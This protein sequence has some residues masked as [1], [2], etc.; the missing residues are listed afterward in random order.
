MLNRSL[1]NRIV[2]SCFH[3]QLIRPLYLYKSIDLRNSKWY[4]SDQKGLNGINNDKT[5]KKD[6]KEIGSSAANDS[7]KKEKADT[8]DGDQVAF[9]FNSPQEN[10]IGNEKDSYQTVSQT[11]PIVNIK[12]LPSEAESRRSNVSKWFSKK[13]D[14]FQATVF[15]ASR[16]LNDATGYSAIEQLKKAIDAEEH[17]VQKYRSQVIKC[18]SEYEGAVN[19]RA[20]SQAEINELLQ[21]KH[22]WTPSDLEQFTMLYRDNHANETAVE[23]T[24]DCLE[25]AE[26]A[27]ED[28]R[29]R[30]AKLIGARY[31]EEQVWSDKIRRASTWGT[32]GLMGFNVVLFLVVQLGLEPWKRKRLVG[33]FE[34]KVRNV[35]DTASRDQK[36]MVENLEQKIA[37]FID[38]NNT[39]SEKQHIEPEKSFTNIKDRLFS[40]DLY[41]LSQFRPIELLSLA[42]ISIGFGFVLGLITFYIGS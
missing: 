22:Q 30:A 15:T 42:G 10:N 7:L 2:F 4:S 23:S 1:G 18:K 34:E 6:Q 39:S 24:K 40:S 21:R 8:V 38:S 14:E 31:R 37:K 25:K 19:S 9:N 35:L 20:E 11:T 32:W 17:N 36:E 27:L 16:A 3:S 26:S 13:M 5:N 28:S 12:E 41:C 33:S 29:S